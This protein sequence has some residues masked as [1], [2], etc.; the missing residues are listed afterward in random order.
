MQCSQK[1]KVWRPLI[2]RGSE[3]TQ[4]H[5]TPRQKPWRKV[6]N[7]H[8]ENKNSY[9]RK[10]KIFQVLEQAGMKP[11]LSGELKDRVDR[12]LIANETDADHRQVVSELFNR[13]PALTRKPSREAIKTLQKVKRR[14]GLFTPEQESGRKIPLY[15]RFYVQIASAA[16]VILIAGG[17]SLTLFFRNEPIAVVPQVIADH[18]VE[19]VEGINKDIYLCDSTYVWVNEK[20]RLTYPK[21]F[22]GERHVKLDGHA[23]FHVTH[24]AEHPFFVHTERLKVRV[25]GTDFHVKEDVES[26]CSEVLL[27]EGAVEVFAGNRKIRLKPGEK[28]TYDHLSGNLTVEMATHETTTTWRTDAIFANQKTI[29]ELLTMIANFYDIDIRYNPATFDDEKYVFGFDKHAPIEKVMTVISELGGGFGYE[30]SADGKEIR[31]NDTL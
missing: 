16:A 18:V 9:K 29:P 21:E 31:I 1:Y 4:Q 3:E 22:Q 5:K 24:D 7:M 10:G 19:A 13:Q 25:L 27:Y 28:L 2:Q 14:L 12:W 26:N 23:R 8:K 20:S 15:R 17:V 6:K 30:F 11:E